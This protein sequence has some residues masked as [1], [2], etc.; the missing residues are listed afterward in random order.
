M[1]L[2][3]AVFDELAWKA[4]ATKAMALQE[5]MLRCNENRSVDNRLAWRSLIDSGGTDEPVTSVILFYFSTWD[6]TGAVERGLGKDAAIQ[7]QHVGD[8]ADDSCFDAE[9][10]SFLLELSLRV[11]SERKK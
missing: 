6:G 4:A 10:Y 2:L 7:K 11:R 9:V 3:G 1:A 5:R 8:A